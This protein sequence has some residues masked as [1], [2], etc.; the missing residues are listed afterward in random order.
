MFISCYDDFFLNWTIWEK[1][2]ANLTFKKIV[3]H[4]GMFIS[5][6]KIS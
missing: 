3:F 5:H 4:V 6:V 1:T 2:D